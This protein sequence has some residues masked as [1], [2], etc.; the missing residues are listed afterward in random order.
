M[1]GA[2][3]SYRNGTYE[4][5]GNKGGKKYFSQFGSELDITSIVGGLY[6]R[7]YIGD[8]YMLGAVYG[9][10]L[11]VDLKTD[12]NVKA[13]IDGHTVGAQ[14]AMGYDAR[15]THREVLTPSLTATYNYIKFKDANDVNGKKASIGAV[16]NV[17]LEAALKYEYQFNNQYQLPT[18]GYIK[19][20]VIQTI[21][22]GGKVKINEKE[23]DDT[24]YNETL[25]RIEI[26]AD[27]ELI[28]NFSVG[29]F[30]NY[31]FGSEYK[32]WG[33]GGNIRYVW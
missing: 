18:T 7:K 2:F 5:D 30:G 12:T 4:N 10:K 19:P 24:V 27:A 25:G 32:A 26:G 29:A 3:G 11:D 15:L 1:I 33:I 28:R 17:E 31:T 8:F 6:Y 20:S 16:N 14:A 21:A 13:T 9:G 22:N 23:Y